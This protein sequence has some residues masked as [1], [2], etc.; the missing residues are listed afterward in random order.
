MRRFILVL[1]IS[2]VGLSVMLSGATANA[3]KSDDSI[4]IGADNTFYAYVKAGEKVS[5][6]FLRVGFKSSDPLA[7]ITVDVEA[8]G[9]KK[10]ECK[11]QKK[12]AA[13]KGCLFS[14]RTAVESGIWRI[15]FKLDDSAGKIFKEASPS[16]R[17]GGN[18]FSWDITIKGEDGSEKGRI[19]TD[20]YAFRQPP[21]E[22][23][24]G[25]DIDSYYVSEDGYIYKSLNK[26]Y[27]GQTSIL[28][29]DSIGIRKNQD[30]ISA[31]RSA[32][33]G[34]D[35]L[36]PALGSCGNRYKLFFEEPAGNLPAEA[37]RWDGETDWVLPTIK[38]PEISELH[39]SP[40][41]TGDQLSGTISFFMRN[42][43]GQYQIKID[44]DNDGSFDGQN[45]VVLYEQLKSLSSTL[46]QVRYQGV[47]K[48]GQIIFPSQKI[49]IKVEIT[50]V[51]EIHF[52]AVDVE[53][54][55]GIEVTRVNGTN[56]PTTRLCWNDN[57]LEPISNVN[58]VTQE[59][60]G[61]SCPDSSGG[62]HG[63]GFGS[64]SWGDK[65]YIDDWTYASVKIDGK[66]V[67]HYPEEEN[68]NQLAK[69][70]NNTLLIIGGIVGAI[71]IIG[72]V[73]TFL[74][75]RKG[76]GNTPPIDGP[77]AM[78]PPTIPPTGGNLPPMN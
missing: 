7:A 66:N 21:S 12:I 14:E 55:T 8:P 47:D 10:Q 15:D 36:S 45:D 53:G 68:E 11:I 70:N 24:V 71:V 13:G 54:R 77:P 37:T 26:G 35:E 75:M 19:W 41:E 64:L 27:D 51:A 48:N 52:V 3:Y 28:M 34:D 1:F 32:P 46:Q 25:G 62:V 40:E 49:G 23:H 20:R 2:V 61:R 73:V 67:I 57:D 76:K 22:G 56:A 18:M 31:Y 74:V 63:W 78:Q 5:I 50:K 4:L 33:V 44:V 16:V 39:F 6:S 38:R 42:F 60:D 9:L 59:V 69:T 72:A 17:W 43:I 30:C 65:R 58:L 29:A